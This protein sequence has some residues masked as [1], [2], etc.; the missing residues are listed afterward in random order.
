MLRAAKRM[1]GY[2]IIAV[3]GA[4]GSAAD[5]YFD[6]QSW[7][8][9]YLDV[10]AG[11]WLSGRHVL[12]APQVLG[13][14]NEE[15]KTIEV[16]AQ[17]RTGAQ[18]P[19]REVDEPVSRAYEME[20]QSYFGWPAYWTAGGGFAAPAQLSP[21]GPEPAAGDFTPSG[22]AASVQ[23]PEIRDLRSVNEV[24]GYS[25]QAVDGGI[26]KLEDLILDDEAW[27]VR[28]L[29]VDTKP[30][31]PGGQVIVATDWVTD[32]RWADRAISVD[33][34]RQAVKKSPPYD[35]GQPVNSEYERKLY[36]H[37]GKGEKP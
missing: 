2:K 7:T 36:E 11:G 6:G 13:D 16:G 5:W 37:Y 3:D 27:A 18:Q 26:G 19:P 35:A 1:R 15:T 31:W 32:I 30:W 29:L 17:Q 14:V 28:Y 24:A 4:I 22:G 33:L 8:I 12:L 25:I 20:L 23:S 9:R 34:T 21:M 10:D